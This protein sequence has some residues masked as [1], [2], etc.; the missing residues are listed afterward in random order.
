MSSITSVTPVGE[1]PEKFDGVDFKRWQQKMLFYLI[2]LNLVKV[3]NEDAPKAKDGDD[4]QVIAAI[5]AWKQ[6]DFLC[7]NYILNGLDNTLYNV[8]CS[9]PTAKE[10]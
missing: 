8:Y 1:K 9:I 3:L 5:D 6:S 2:T 10:H 7:K 4:M